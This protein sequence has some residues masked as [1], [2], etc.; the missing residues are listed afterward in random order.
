MEDRNSRNGCAL[1]VGAG[2]RPGTGAAIAARAAREGLHVFIAGRTQEKLDALVTHIEAEGGAA[3]AVVADCTDA[4]AVD[5]LFAR[6]AAHGAPLRLAVH[7]M[8]APNMPHGFLKTDADFFANHWRTSTY[9]GYLIG[10][11]T[12]RQ[13]LEQ[14]EDEHFGRGTLIFTGASASLRGKAKFSAFASA[15]S[16]LRTMA[17]SIAREFGPQ[18]IH[19]AHVIIDGVIDG[20]FVRNA[21]GNLAKLWIKS[22]GSDGALDPEAIADAFWAIHRQPRSAWTQEMDLRPFKEEW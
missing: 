21:G 15:K 17:Q 12:I 16:G 2:D 4:E 18:G 13:M 10:Q 22:K 5:A 20:Q 19:V 6:I 11:G 8:A 1:I 3:S 9:A 14:D 7:N